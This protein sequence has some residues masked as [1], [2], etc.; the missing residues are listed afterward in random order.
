[1]VELDGLALAGV[2]DDGGVLGVSLA[3]NLVAS[4]G[5]DGCPEGGRCVR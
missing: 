3:G 4:L 2:E 5:L 1:M